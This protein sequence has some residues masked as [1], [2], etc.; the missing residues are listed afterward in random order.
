MA[1][2]LEEDE[3]ENLKIVGESFLNLNKELN[4][5]DCPQF[6]FLNPF[7][8]LNTRN[9]S[10]ILFDTRHNYKDTINDP[11]VE[12]YSDDNNS[13]LTGVKISKIMDAIKDAKKADEIK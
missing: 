3:D 6:I 10:K 9:I 13:K 5:K 2:T 8:I 7:I 11:L 4:K 12:I 1:D